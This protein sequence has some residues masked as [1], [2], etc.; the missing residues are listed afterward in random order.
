MDTSLSLSFFFSL[1]TAME[2]LKQENINA[3]VTRTED[4]ITKERDGWKS[5]SE[6]TKDLKEITNVTKNI[7]SNV[8][9]TSDDS[10]KSTFESA[11]KEAKLFK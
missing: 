10:T 4:I 6:S 7:K 2:K 1:N 5:L 11:Q 9:G 8:N 3:L